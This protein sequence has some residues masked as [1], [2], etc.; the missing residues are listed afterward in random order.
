MSHS[1]LECRLT[2][3]LQYILF[4]SMEYSYYCLWVFHEG[5]AKMENTEYEVHADSKDGLSIKIN[6]IK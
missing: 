6:K 2:V 1:K 3:V 4:N 5:V